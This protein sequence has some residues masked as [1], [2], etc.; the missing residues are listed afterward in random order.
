LTVGGGIAAYSFCNVL[1][2]I[3]HRQ[4]RLGWNATS[5]IS[6]DTSTVSTLVDLV[7]HILILHMDILITSTLCKE[8]WRCHSGTLCGGGGCS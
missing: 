6:I 8:C 1:Q 4:P 5:A 2:T 3:Y 7:L